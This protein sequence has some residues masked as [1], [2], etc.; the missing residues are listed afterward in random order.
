MS[1]LVLVCTVIRGL[2]VHAGVTPALLLT[3]LH[4]MIPRF[5]LAICSA[6]STFINV[7]FLFEALRYIQVVLFDVRNRYETRIGHFARRSP[8]SGKE[9]VAEGSYP[10]IAMWVARMISISITQITRGLKPITASS[11]CVCINLKAAASAADLLSLK[12]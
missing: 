8:A 2:C 10:C 11:M 3:T 5:K 1:R 12:T 7:S 4:K 9:A 6:G